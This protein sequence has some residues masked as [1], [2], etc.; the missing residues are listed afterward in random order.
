M[1]DP[2]FY[3]IVPALSAGAFLLTGVLFHQVAIA[4]DR[5]WSLTVLA[6]SHTAFAAVQIATTLGIG[7]AIDRFTARGV[8]RWA[9]VPLFISS[10]ALAVGDTLFSLWMMMIFAGMA[11]G[12]LLPL[13]ITL[14]TELYGTRHIGAI[15]SLSL[16]INVI[17]T[18]LAPVIYGLLLDADLGSHSLGWFGLAYL[19]LATIGIWAGLG[20]EARRR[21]VGL[22]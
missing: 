7:F 20:Y 18:A 16:M 4:N 12:V 22:Q 19:L 8:S 2:V 10:L 1:R 9:L 14:L 21:R 3:C 11:M 17:G 15:K 5:G 13:S 6:S